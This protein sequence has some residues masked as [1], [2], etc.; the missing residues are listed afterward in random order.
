MAEVTSS[1]NEAANM[2]TSTADEAVAEGAFTADEAVTMVT[3]NVHSGRGCGKVRVQG[4]PRWWSRSR[5]QC[6]KV[7]ANVVSTV[8]VALPEVVAEVAAKVT[9]KVTP[10]VGGEAETRTPHF[11]HAAAHATD[12]L[13]KFTDGVCK[14][15]V[16]RARPRRSS[17]GPFSRALPFARTGRGVVSDV[18]FLAEDCFRAKRFALEPAVGAGGS[19]RQVLFTEPF[20]LRGTFPTLDALHRG[21][22][23]HG[24]TTTQMSEKLEMG[25]SFAVQ[26]NYQHLF[27]KKSRVTHFRFFPCTWW[28]YTGVI[29][30]L[31]LCP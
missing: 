13:H 28:L 12:S 2:V 11:A 23:V 24:L 17:S 22:G 19:R 26:A 10:K 25:L 31:D 3:S 4:W 15:S 14:F 5:P 8:A 1:A 27:A 21:S 20:V 30:E 7:L 16:W 29:S 18:L 9:P 6:D